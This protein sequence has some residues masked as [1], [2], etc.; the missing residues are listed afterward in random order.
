MSL[1]KLINRLY[2]F[3][4]VQLNKSDSLTDLLEILNKLVYKT[5]EPQQL[6]YNILTINMEN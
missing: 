5:W 3:L 1:L 4:S 6:V 2:A